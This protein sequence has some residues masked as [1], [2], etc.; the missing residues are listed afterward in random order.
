MTLYCSLRFTVLYLLWQR[1]WIESL[2]WLSTAV[3]VKKYMN[4]INDGTKDLLWHLIHDLFN[5]C[6]NQ[7]SI[8]KQDLGHLHMQCSLHLH[9]SWFYYKDGTSEMLHALTFDSIALSKKSY[10]CDVSNCI[11]SWWVFMFIY[12]MIE[13]LTSFFSFNFEI[14]IPE[15]IYFLLLY[16]YNPL[17]LRGNCNFSSTTFIC[18]N[19]SYSSDSVEYCKIKP[20]SQW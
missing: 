15:Y 3:Q 1:S 18:W 2:C 9:I 20:T 5:M 14:L 7:P 8:V 12:W 10:M 19:T 4:D 17:Y 11:C 13:H 16:T 6:T